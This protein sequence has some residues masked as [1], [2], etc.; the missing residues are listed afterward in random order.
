VRGSDS[1]SVVPRQSHVSDYGGDG[2]DVVLG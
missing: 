2:R 1:A